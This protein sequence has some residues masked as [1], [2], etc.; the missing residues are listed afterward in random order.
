MFICYYTASSTIQTVLSAT[1]FHRISP[2]KAGVAD[3]N[4]RSGIAPCPEETF[5]L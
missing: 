5:G 2:A 1:E 4:R 3:F